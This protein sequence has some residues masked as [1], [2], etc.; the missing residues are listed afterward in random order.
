MKA[1]CVRGTYRPANNYEPDRPDVAQWTVMVLDERFCEVYA[2]LV[3]E[4]AK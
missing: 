2:A 4:E 3:K 1:L